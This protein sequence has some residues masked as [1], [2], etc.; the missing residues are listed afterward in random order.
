MIFLNPAILIGLL[1]ASIPIVIHLLNLRQ[2]RRVE[3]SSLMLIKQIQTSSL[4][5]FKIREWILLAIR[6]LIIFFLVATFS[7]PVF[8]SLQAGSGFST[9]TKTSAMILVDV[10]PSMSYRDAFG[11]DVFRQAKSAALRVLDYFSESDEIFIVFSNSLQEPIAQSASEAKKTLAQA[12]VA[13]FGFP[14]QTCIEK[15]AGWLQQ[16]THLSR[17]LYVVSDFQRTGVLT[18]DSLNL[19]AQGI[20]LFFIDVAPKK[21]ENIGVGE[22]EVLTKVF[23][24]QKPIRVKVSAVKTGETAKEVEVKWG[25]DKKIAAQGAIQF[26][27]QSVGETVLTAS[28]TRTGFLSGELELPKD[29]LELDNKHYLAFHIPEKLRICLAYSDERECVYVK[30]ALESFFEGNFF[31]LTLVPESGLDSRSFAPFD[32]LIFCGVKNLSTSTIQ[33]TVNFVEQGGGLLL[34]APINAS[35]NSHNDLLKRLGGGELKPL[36]LSQPTAIDNIEVQHPIFEGIFASK[37][38]LKSQLSVSESGIG[39]I[40]KINDY[41]NSPVE[42]RVLGYQTNKNFLTTSR[43]GN[44]AF[45]LCPTMP[46]QEATNFVLQ[47]LFTPLLYRAI[48]TAAVAT[49]AK[50]ESFI[51]GEEVSL[52]LPSSVSASDELRIEK[53]SG[54]IMI[55]TVQF[56]TGASRLFIAPALYDELGVYRLFKTIGDDN[57]TLAEFAVNLSSK[58][59]SLEKIELKLLK[60][61]LLKANV[62]ETRLAFADASEK[63]DEVSETISGSRYGLGIWKHLLFIVVLL[64]VAESILGRKAEA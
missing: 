13:T 15:G 26:E 10:S 22:V 54:K 46:T 2:R 32:V 40:F 61:L 3:F 7:K 8:P 37:Q 63:L 38:K 58:E 20:N 41:L 42:S 25:L 14:L 62:E 44:G 34:F 21:Q 35:L 52:A 33:K 47:P 53:P 48:F 9:Q 17:E 19:N 16:S 31:E 30:L 36:A 6:S 23:E 60:D 18:G 24:P 4:K 57:I 59:S 50:N 55:P 56:R 51:I 64:L 5:R 29:N 45:I 12:S 27:A 43:F 49:Q 11:N 28:P 1:A 39:T